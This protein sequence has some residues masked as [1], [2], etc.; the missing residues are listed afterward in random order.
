MNYE[1]WLKSTEYG[2]KR[3]Y[4]VSDIVIN[5]NG[6]RIDFVNNFHYEIN[7]YILKGLCQTDGGFIGLCNDIEQEFMSQIKNV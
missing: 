4:K 2:L 6:M 7:A 5:D 1:E 3:R